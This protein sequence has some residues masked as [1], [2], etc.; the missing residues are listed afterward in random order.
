MIGWAILP[1]GVIITVW[2]LVKK[3]RRADFRYYVL[4]AV[5]WTVIAVAGDYVFIIRLLNPADGYYQLDV[6]LY[7]V[8][9]FAIPLIV[10]WWKSTATR[11]PSS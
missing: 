11:R 10:G 2:V 7:Y 4:L 6:Y 9:M 5:V 3:I 8:L 1:V